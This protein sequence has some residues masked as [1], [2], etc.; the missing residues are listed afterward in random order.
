MFLELFTKK[1]ESWKK[2]KFFETS[3][4]ATILDEVRN[5]SFV[6]ITGPSGMG[7]S[8]IVKLV[9]LKLQRT[10]DYHILPVMCPEDIEKYLDPKIKQIYIID[11]ICGKF[12]VEQSMINS[13]ERVKCEILKYRKDNKE[14][15]V[16]GTCRLQISV[17]SPF[18][19]LQEKFEMTE[20]NL[21]Q[22]NFLY[23]K[24]EKL[25]IAACHIDE[26]TIKELDNKILSA[27]DMFP[28]LCMMY[29]ALKSKPGVRFFEYPLQAIK[30]ELD[31]MSEQN[32]CCFIG[33]ALIVIYNNK[34]YK[35][36]LQNGNDQKFK[37]VFDGVLEDLVLKK[38]PSKSS[39]LEGLQALKRN[40]TKESESTITASHDKMFDILSLYFGKRIPKTIL[41]HGSGTFI[42]E[43]FLFESVKEDCDELKIVIPS[44]LEHS[45]FKRMVEEIENNRFYNVFKNVQVRNELYQ[46]KFISFLSKDQTIIQ[47]LLYNRW[48][49]Y[50]SAVKGCKLLV[51]F[52]LSEERNHQD[53][54]MD[55]PE[56]DMNVCNSDSDS[57][58]D[59][60]SKSRSKYRFSKD[61]CTIKRDADRIKFKN[62]PM[63]A[64]CE[65]GYIDIVQCLVENYYNTDQ[66]D[67]NLPTPLFS[68][69]KYGRQDVVDFLL[70]R[71]CKVNEVD[72]NWQIAL[73]AACEN[74]NIY[75]VDSL[76]HCYSNVNVCD[77]DGVTPLHVACEHSNINLVNILLK[78]KSNVNRSTTGGL[79]PLHVA[80]KHGNIDI[81][82]SL[83]EYGS[84]VNICDFDRPT[85]LHVA[86]EHSNINIVNILLKYN[87]SVNLFGFDRLTPLHIACKHGNI[88]IV[89]ILL[90]HNSSMN[91]CDYDGLAPLHFACIYGHTDVVHILMDNNCDIN[92]SVLDADLTRNHIANIYFRGDPHQPIEFACLHGHTDI[93]KLLLDNNCDVIDNDGF[94]LALEC[95]FKG[96]SVD[97]V[98]LL[99]RNKCN[100]NQCH[101]GTNRSLLIGA[102]DKKN[103]N[104][105]AFVKMLLSH[106]A[107]DVNITDCDNRNALYYACI[108]GQADVV[109]LLL[110]HEACDVNITDC[111]NRNALYHA[112]KNGQADV[113][114]LLLSHE[115][116]GVN[117][118]DHYNCNALHYACENG[119]ANVVELL[120]RLHCNVNFNDKWM[121][122][123]LF[124]ACESGHV[125]IVKMLINQDNCMIDVLD[126]DGNGILHATC[127]LSCQDDKLIINYTRSSRLNATKNEYGE[128]IRLL[129]GKSCDVN[130]LNSKGQSVLHA[131]CAFGDTEIVA[132]LL[133]NNSNVNQ[134]DKAMKTPLFIAC[135]EGYIDIVKLLIDSKCEVFNHSLN[136]QTVLHAVCSGRDRS[137]WN[138]GTV[139]TYTDGHRAILVLLIDENCD[140]NISDNNSQTPLHIA[141]YNGYETLVE[142]LI[143][144]KCVVDKH[145]EWMKTPLILAVEGGHI[146]VVK[147]LVKDNKC[148][149]NIYD[150]N[151]QT[152]LHRAC[153]EGYADI[154][155]IFLKRNSNINWWDKWRKTPLILAVEGRHIEVVKLLVKDNK[156]DINICD[157]NGQT[158]LHR[159]C[160][161]GYADIAK[162][163]LK[164]NSDINKCDKWKKTP[165]I[166]AVEGSHR[167]VV[168]L[169]VEFKCDI[170]IF[171]KDGRTACDIAVENQFVDIENILNT[172][173]N[174]YVCRLQ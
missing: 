15:R 153:S 80:C 142:I 105:E 165:L 115:A 149:I 109:K 83:L 101:P 25:K 5:K 118:I 60:E 82:N 58:S 27:Y 152:P 11:D 160:S 87:S 63:V 89:N 124:I 1:I 72:K 36:L 49:L 170:N 20:C 73:H 9:A 171:D 120:L 70:R 6:V 21:L 119:Q 125:D 132:I 48:P 139:E 98:D 130:V 169:L 71:R 174:T 8:T 47:K 163:F 148:D 91:L 144:N 93:V 51:Q 129:L 45:Y 90:K 104:Q 19:K 18:R 37:D 31:E 108:N 16:L 52:I 81:V 131:A 32:E 86:C 99:L 13:W 64:A 88:D 79:A 162:I 113:V 69:C 44:E 56:S 92:K 96:G 159:A 155:E 128:I 12:S 122:T 167:K 107:C 168:Q 164:R 17:S 161:E 30:E 7:K 38:Q 42:A 29:A 50:L 4:V 84:D 53:M 134:C 140:V 55:K 154:A 46:R 14:F 43:R 54:L 77:T 34:L 151:G 106:E 61:K 117:I 138:N 111:D 65:G 76:L 112:C 102:C 26:E 116:C 147:F 67:T 3:A 158:P 95:A 123:P 137:K 141:C 146:E 103:G 33:L 136:E 100:I 133:R 121:K 22:E 156:C 68:A 150:A 2:G 66:S 59:S 40:Y 35:H 114:K 172:M 157:A 145:D 28:L 127:G 126:V 24:E 78:Y 57:D 110:S 173:N 39:V 97:V 23:S 41:T 62:S 94:S 74:G 75:I 85:P 166:L 143:R 10:D 135:E